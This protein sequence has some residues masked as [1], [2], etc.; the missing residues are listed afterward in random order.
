MKVLVTGHR[1]YVGTVMVPVL[2]QSGH[3]VAGCDSD[4]YE[5]CTYE[6]GGKILEIPSIRKD[7]RDVVVS[8]LSGFD[9]IIHLAA[10]SNDPLSDLTPEITYNI[11]HRAS[12]RL[13]EL[14]KNDG[15][16]RFLVLLHRAATMVS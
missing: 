13:A 16:R 3:E 6:G 14:A 7:V 15:V 8:D 4:L 12:V 11:N 9:A 2:L 10:L 1:G 5:R